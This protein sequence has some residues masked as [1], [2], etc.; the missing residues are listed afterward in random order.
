[1]NVLRWVFFLP[2]GF[3]SSVL[4]GYLATTVTELFGGAS[5]Y[6]WMLSGAVSGVVFILVALAIAPKDHPVAKWVVFSVVVLLGVASA[7]G[8][9]LVGKDMVRSLAGVAMA[10]A[11]FWLIRPFE[12]VRGRADG[13]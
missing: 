8:P 2:A 11:A 13:D 7:L 10:I 6:S 12:N 5:W 9:I 1:M 4:S 3:V